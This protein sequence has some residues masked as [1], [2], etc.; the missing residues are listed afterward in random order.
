[1]TLQ[2]VKRCVIA[3]TVWAMGLLWVL[4]GGGPMSASALVPAAPVPV[5]TP[6]GFPSFASSRLL[7]T[8]VGLGGAQAGVPALGAVASL[9]AVRGGGAALGGCV[10]V[11][12]GAVSGRAPPG[13]WWSGIGWRITWKDFAGR[14]SSNSGSSCSTT[15]MTL[16]QRSSISKRL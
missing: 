2:V 5:T 4:A 12:A 15:S 8:A 9:V 6:G 11:G 13:G 7:A 16:P 1:M 14:R 10:G 3:L